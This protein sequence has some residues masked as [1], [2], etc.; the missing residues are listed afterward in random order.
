MT[1]RVLNSWP[2]LYIVEIFKNIVPKGFFGIPNIY[3]DIAI[4]VTQPLWQL[5]RNQKLQ[6]RFSRNHV[7]RAS[8]G[9]RAGCTEPILM[10]QT[11]ID[12]ELTSFWPVVKS[13]G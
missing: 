12:A 10:F 7:F 13:S 4:L 1:H 8:S 6:T 3:G 5:H 11:L 9:D 2:P